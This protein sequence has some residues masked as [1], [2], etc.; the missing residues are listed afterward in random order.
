MSQ[1]DNIT[2]HACD[3]DKEFQALKACIRQAVSFL[4]DLSGS[5]FFLNLISLDIM[6]N[7]GYHDK[8]VI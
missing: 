1:K 8:I 5:L 2:K 3:K 7:F 4:G 6:L